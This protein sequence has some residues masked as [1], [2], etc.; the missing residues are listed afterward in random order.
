MGS[1]MEQKRIQTVLLMGRPG[2][3]KGT[4]A[5]LLSEKFGWEHFST[6]DR[7]KELRDG[8]GILAKRV[9]DAYASA[10][11]FPDWFATYLFEDKLLT[12]PADAGIVCEGYPRTLAQAHI[13]DETM[14]W[15]GR[16]YTVLMLDIPEAESV[17]RQL[18]RGQTED[19]PDS[20]TEEKIK[21][22]LAAYH[23]STEP[24]AEYFKAK[25]S[26]KEIDGTPSIEAIHANIVSHLS[27]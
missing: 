9:H 3:G 21:I 25:G 23:A 1:D 7:F 15:L 26:Y 6:G 13:F 27:L 19:R 16:P 12:M 4:Q 14:D 11:L 18:S 5:K 22:R 10:K 2:S 20:S 24:V 17:A 8:D